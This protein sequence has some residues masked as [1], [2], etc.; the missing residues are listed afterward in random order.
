LG[1]PDFKCLGPTTPDRSDADGI[2]QLSPVLGCSIFFHQGHELKVNAEG[3][4]GFL[5]RNSGSRIGFAIGSLINLGGNAI[6]LDPG[7]HF[8]VAFDDEFSVL[9]EFLKWFLGALH[10]LVLAFFVK[11]DFLAGVSTQF[12]KQKNG[13]AIFGPAKWIIYAFEWDKKILSNCFPGYRVL[14]FFLDLLQNHFG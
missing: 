1:F 9:S 8:H 13:I 6:L 7:Q 5:Y 10:G 3:L 4:D 2:L 14:N 11:N 12:R